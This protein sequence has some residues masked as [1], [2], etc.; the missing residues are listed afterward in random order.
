MAAEVVVIGASLGG[1]HALIRVLGGL[2]RAFPLPVVVV[3]HRCAESGEPLKSAIQKHIQLKVKEAQDKEVPLPG[4]VYLA[5]ADYHLLLDRGCMQ[6]SVDPPVN[7]ARPSL[8][9]LFESAA[10]AYGDAVVAV[11]LTG[12]SRDGALGAAAIKHRGGKVIVQDPNSAESSL[13]PRAAIAAVPVDHIVPLSEIPGLL[14]R[15]CASPHA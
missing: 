1:Y 4:H 10:D 2:T 3:Q 7:S 9:V 15:W 11:V 6:L 8:D 5:P 13:M 14:N 12:A